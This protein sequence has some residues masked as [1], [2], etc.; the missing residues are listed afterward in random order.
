MTSAASPSEQ[1]GRPD[2]AGL[3]RD[4]FS[5]WASGSPKQALE[6][7]EQALQ[8]KPNA[9][10]L[11]AA[12]LLADGL[13]DQPRRDRLL[14]EL[15]TKLQ[16]QV[17]RM[18]AIGRMMRDALAGGGKASLDLATVDKVLRDMPPR[19]R[20]NAEF[21]VGRFLLN[22]GQTESARKYLQLAADSGQTHPD[23]KQIA[24]NSLRS[25]A[26]GKGP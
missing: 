5:L 23:L 12:F 6:A 25:P 24:A 8:A 19:T 2:P 22:R 16:R 18:V 21:L 4:G 20:G 11:I 26:A 10:N 13:G 17:P 3:E 9:A 1:R 7:L 14:E 15:C